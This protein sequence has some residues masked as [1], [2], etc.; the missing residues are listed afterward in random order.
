V[1]KGRRDIRYQILIAASIF[2]G[3]FF[4]EYPL[5]FLVGYWSWGPVIHK[6]LSGLFL[7]LNLALAEYARKRL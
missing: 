3:L 2:C 1:P 6:V 7:V 4:V 5:L